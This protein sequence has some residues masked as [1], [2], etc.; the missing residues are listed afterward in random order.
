MLEQTK[1]SERF[2]L[3]FFCYSHSLMLNEQGALQ[4]GGWKL[5]EFE[6]KLTG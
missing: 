3:L 1:Q 6:D 5:F 2:L 4:A